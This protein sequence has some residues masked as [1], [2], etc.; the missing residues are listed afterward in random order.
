MRAA[1]LPSPDIR[2]LWHTD[3]GRKIAVSARPHEQALS[4]GAKTTGF[5]V[6]RTLRDARTLEPVVRAGLQTDPLADRRAGEFDAEIRVDEQHLVRIE[7]ARHAVHEV[8]RVHHS[9]R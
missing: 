9:L 4:S 1:R 7:L 2:S 5:V 8:R 6:E 3:A